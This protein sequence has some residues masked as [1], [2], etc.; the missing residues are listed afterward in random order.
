VPEFLK[1]PANARAVAEM[2]FSDG[3]LR[4]LFFDKE[5]NEIVESLD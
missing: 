3:G 4:Q 1:S 2:L 5:A